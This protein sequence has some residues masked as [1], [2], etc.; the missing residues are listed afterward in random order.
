MFIEPQR[1][2]FDLRWRMFGIHVRVHPTFW[3]FSAAFG[4]GYLRAGLPFLLLWIACSFLSILIHEL[5]HVIMGRL[6]GQPGNIILYG[7]GGLAVGQ[8]QYA[9]RWQRI[10][11]SLAGPAA[12]F[13]FLGLVIGT[14][15]LFQEYLLHRIDPR[16]DWRG[17]FL[18][19]FG[20][21]FFMNLAWNLL[22]LIPV[23]PLDGGQV[24][25]E[26]CDGIAPD[27]GLQIAHGLSFLIAGLI[28]IYAILARV[29]PNLWYPFDREGILLPLFF[30]I[31]A[32]ENLML[33][34]R[35]GGERRQQDNDYDW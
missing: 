25:S 2:A 11:I 16:A 26:V 23:Y 5:G 28:T 18:A 35:A 32:F 9:R 22:N 8:Y 17:Y 13:L 1:T 15:Y 27:R 29:R 7:M 3:L 4:W 6:A 34:Q 33:Y 14:S 12:G 31:M 30:G 19:T 24:L 21:L 10:A 20:M